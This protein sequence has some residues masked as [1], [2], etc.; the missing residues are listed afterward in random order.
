V[1][2][3][4]PADLETF[5]KHL[6]QI[7]EHM[8]YDDQY[9]IN[10][11]EVPM[12]FELIPEKT[13]NSKGH[14][15]V[16]ILSTGGEKRHFTLV[17]A[18]TVSG[19]FLPSTVVF[20]GTVCTVLYVVNNNIVYTLWERN[21]SVSSPI[22]TAVITHSESVPVAISN[23]FQALSPIFSNAVPP[24]DTGAMPAPQHDQQDLR[25]P[26]K[27]L[28]LIISRPGEWTI[29]ATLTSDHCAVLKLETCNMLLITQQYILNANK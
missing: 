22:D 5:Y 4:L 2:Q 6:H 13:V 18:I 23:S 19:H 14:K 17:L 1:S 25:L 7:R 27:C 24:R 16:K 29:L 21:S 12:Y 10:M 15:D 11:D 28:N 9:I 20:K 26:R 8:D 3:K